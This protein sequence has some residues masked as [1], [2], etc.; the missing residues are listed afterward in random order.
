[1]EERPSNAIAVILVNDYP[2]LAAF[3]NGLQTQYGHWQGMVLLRRQNPR[4]W[5]FQSDI[6]GADM[7]CYVTSGG[8]TFVKGCRP[9]DAEQAYVEFL[10][11]MA[12]KAR[13]DAEQAVQAA[14][15]RLALAKAM[16]RGLA[17]YTAEG[18]KREFPEVHVPNAVDVHG[19]GDIFF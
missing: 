15:K 8:E 3:S 12:R 17:E 13:R 9:E 5:L 7:H 19:Y 2:H 11:F 14:K 16:R 18:K 10:D 1:M 6:I 4:R